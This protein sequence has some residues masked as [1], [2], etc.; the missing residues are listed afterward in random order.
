MTNVSFVIVPFC[1]TKMALNLKITVVGD[2]I[3]GKT[4]MLIVYTSDEFPEDYVP[5]V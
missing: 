5:T 1:K 3:V 2:G 4:C